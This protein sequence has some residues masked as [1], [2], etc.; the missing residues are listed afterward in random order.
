MPHNSLNANL[1]TAYPLKNP[2]PVDFIP[3]SPSGGFVEV[4]AFAKINLFLVVTG[5]RD[6]GYHDIIS[7]M[8]GVGI[9]DTLQISKAESSTMPLVTLDTNVKDLPTGDANI[10][11]KAA[12]KILS[13]FQIPTPVY[14]KLNKRIPMG[15]GLGGGS[16]NAAAT[17][18]GLNQLFKL[19]IPSQQLFDIGKEIGADVPFCLMQNDAV[20]LEGK[21]NPITA[22]ATGIGEVLSPL[23]PHPSCYIALAY[24]NTNIS[25]AKIFAKLTKFNYP[26]IDNFLTIYKT[27]DITQ[28]SQALFNSFIPVTAEYCPTIPLLIDGFKKNG[29]LGASMT[30]TGSTVFAY[31]NCKSTAQKACNVLTESHHH[32][33]FLVTQ[34]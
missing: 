19:N 28:I 29:A 21:L 34:V 2:Q 18:L 26:A 14:I 9:H 27:A 15:A 20:G 17:L 16:S 1:P 3:S 6:D 13:K 7:V 31:F 4:E 12:K 8:Q 24:P 10:V 30:G 33:M 25:T 23:P 5:R 11:V 22:L 32:T